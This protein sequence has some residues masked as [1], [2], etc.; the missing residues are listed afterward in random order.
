MTFD[1]MKIIGL[2]HVQSTTVGEFAELKMVFNANGAML[3]PP[4]EQHRDHSAP[5]IVYADDY[6]GN[7]LAAVLNKGQMD[8]RYH[9][10]FSP[11]LVATLV[12]SLASQRDLA[13]LR[14]WSVTYQGHPVNL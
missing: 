10:D 8:V 1:C 5:G 6:R 11:A 13:F 3:F 12:R 9:K 4:S 2:E 7:A 14:T